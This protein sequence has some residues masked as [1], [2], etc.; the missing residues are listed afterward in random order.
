MSKASREKGQR[1]EREVRDLLRQYGFLAVRDGR[2]SA[3]LSHDVPDVH[4]EV[5]RCERLSLP[6]WTR[7]AEMDAKEG[8]VPV[9]AYRRSQEPWRASVPLDFLLG[10]LVDR[11]YGLR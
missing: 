6:E 9:V 1:G 10:L 8:E 5:K 7:Q 2:L 11:K 3:D 4:F